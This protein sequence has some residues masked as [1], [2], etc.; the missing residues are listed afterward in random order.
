MRPK[1]TILLQTKPG[2]AKK[3]GPVGVFLASV[4]GIFTASQAEIT[5]K[6][7]LN[8]NFSPILLSL[9]PYSHLFSFK[10]PS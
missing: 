9:H 6:P 7:V 4:Q 10:P 2:Y 5:E 1:L 3:V 8:L